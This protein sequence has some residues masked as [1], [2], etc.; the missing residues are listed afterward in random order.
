MIKSNR[1]IFVE[2]HLQSVN[3]LVLAEFELPQ[4]LLKRLDLEVR[5]HLDEINL[6]HVFILNEVFFIIRPLLLISQLLFI[7]LGRF[8]E[9][10]G[11]ELKLILRPHT[12]SCFLLYLL[13]HLLSLEVLLAFLDVVL[14]RLEGEHV[15]ILGKQLIGVFD[16][17]RHAFELIDPF[18]DKFLSKFLV[19]FP[20]DVLAQLL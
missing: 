6:L 8:P 11:I 16:L 5:L 1:F 2:H 10:S 20:F 4:S 13:K 3:L 19:F 18:H 12:L 9:F 15:D 14:V 7:I 17:V